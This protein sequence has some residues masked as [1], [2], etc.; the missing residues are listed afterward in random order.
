MGRK[1]R[2]FTRLQETLDGSQVLARGYVRVSTED[3]ATNGLSLE[4]QEDSI[5]SHADQRGW[6]VDRVY[7]DNG[8][9]AWKASGENRRA[10]GAMI[11]DAR[12]GAFNVL[13][14][15]NQSR[16][17]RD[18]RAQA[19]YINVLEE[20]GVEVVFLNEPTEQDRTTRDLVR[21]IMGAI[22][23][24]ES[25]LK[26]QLVR[27]NMR[28]KSQRGL[29][30]GSAPDGYDYVPSSGA[31]KA[32]AR[33]GV[34]VKIY[35]WYLQERSLTKVALRLIEA[36]I[37]PIRAPYWHRNVI[38]KYLRNTVYAGWI[39]R[40]GER[41]RG[42]HEALVSEETFQKVQKLLEL[43]TPRAKARIDGGS[44][45]VPLAR[46]AYCESSMWLS[47][48][49]S[50]YRY[51]CCS[52]T[53]SRIG[54]A[55][56]PH[57]KQF[58]KV[59]RVRDFLLDEAVLKDVLSLS[60]TQIRGGIARANG[61]LLRA[62]CTLQTALEDVRV[63]L[64]AQRS[65]LKELVGM[66]LSG[67]ITPREFNALIGDY[68]AEHSELEARD[69]DLRKQLKEQPVTR[70]DIDRTV[71]A[72]R[73]FQAAAARGVWDKP[74]RARELQRLVERVEASRSTVMIHYKGRLL[75]TREASLKPMPGQDMRQ[76]VKSGRRRK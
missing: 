1:R 7:R 17:A 10:F 38:R 74:K 25:S 76:S 16:F 27:E 53:H 47:H 41:F 4:H 11:R 40:G 9:S 44:L 69:E 55:P 20:A 59:F 54:V 52:K 46:C 51:Y 15:L 35:R 58:G 28:K 21:G 64:E 39:L 32:N 48:G 71:T 67:E 26:S 24:A 13:L 60:E 62:E 56:C 37:T 33:A 70:E 42:V 68:R 19:H 14:C 29:W 18:L 43:S 45:L 30:I 8:A 3:Q 61:S 66:K 31:L 73:R 36:G 12:E 75:R 5:R 72:V 65:R 23:E 63:Q 2:Q 57:K 50:A 6:R 34:I 22:N 49:Q